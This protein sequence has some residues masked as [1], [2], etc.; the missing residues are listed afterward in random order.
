MAINVSITP[1]DMLK[2]RVVTG[3]TKIPVEII[4]VKEETAKD[5]ASTNYVFDYKAI[6]GEYI[7]VQFKSY[8]SEKW[9]PGLIPVLRA[10]GAQVDEKKGIAGVNLEACQGKKI[11]LTVQPK[12]FEGRQ[13]NEVVDWE[14]FPA[15]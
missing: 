3:K 11:I 5:K 8:F 6:G 10:C 13:M 4:K 12:T 15:A 1:E 14:P 9:M 7:G 2:T